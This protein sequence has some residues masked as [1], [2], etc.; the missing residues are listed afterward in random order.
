[1]DDFLNEGKDLKGGDA[2]EPED[3]LSDHKSEPLIGYP[4]SDTQ[5]QTEKIDLKP[6]T[7]DKLDKP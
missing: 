2:V 7:F 4:S 5:H 1:M 3:V 6:T